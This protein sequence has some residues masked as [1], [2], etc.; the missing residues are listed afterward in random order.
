MKKRSD[1][2]IE[3][4][5]EKVMEAGKREKEKLSEEEKRRE[6]KNKKRNRER[7]GGRRRDDG[8]K[9]KRRRVRVWAP[10]AFCSPFTVRPS[11]TLGRSEETSASVEGGGE[12]DRVEFLIP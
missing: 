3:G 8:C 7:E 12:K 5:R 1:R 11:R 2:E 10:K 6:R 9:S 4:E